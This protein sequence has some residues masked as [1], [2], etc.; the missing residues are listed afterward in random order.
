MAYPEPSRS[1]HDA[2][3]NLMDIEDPDN[4]DETI[5]VCGCTSCLKRMRDEERE[6]YG[7]D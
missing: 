4:E 6:D 3:W 5:Q 7:E 1:D 2:P